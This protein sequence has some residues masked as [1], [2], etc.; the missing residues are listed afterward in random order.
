LVREFLVWL[1]DDFGKGAGDTAQSLSQALLGSLNFWGLLEGTHILALML[2]A[3]TIFIVDLRLL[4]L[5]FRQTPVSVIS[6]KVLPLTVAGFSVVVLTGAALFYAKPLFYY[7]NIWFRAKLMFLLLAMVNIAI[8][9]TRV[10]R[11]QQDW[12][13]L[14]K[15][16]RRARASAVLS[17][18][19]WL[20]VITMGRFIAYDWFECGKALPHWVNVAQ[21]CKAS[22]NGAVDAH[23]MGKLGA[24]AS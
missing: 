11:N 18:M 17:L 21:S 20:A 3:G 22:D 15:P 16:P 24:P 23:A 10:H 9:H 19:S 1:Q 13:T 8:F 2:F 5:T 4:G 12:D 6:N 14:A 7:H